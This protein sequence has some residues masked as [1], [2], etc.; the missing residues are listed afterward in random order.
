M[1]FSWTANPRK[2]DSVVFQ[3]FLPQA[4]G[5]H[6]LALKDQGVVGTA[7]TP[8]YC[9]AHPHLPAEKQLSRG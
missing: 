6:R 4:Y 7:V 2:G 8:L 1:V 3:G 9:C 5:E